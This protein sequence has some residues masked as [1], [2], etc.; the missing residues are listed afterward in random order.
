MLRNNHLKNFTTYHQLIKSQVDE[1]KYFTVNLT[2]KM[3]PVSISKRK[4]NEIYKNIFEKL[5]QWSKIILIYNLTIKNK[6]IHK[7]SEN[8]A[9]DRGRYRFT[10]GNKKWQH[11]ETILYK[12]LLL[13]GIPQI[14]GSVVF[15]CSLNKVYWNDIFKHCFNPQV[16]NN[17]N[18]FCGK[19][20]I[21]YARSQ[22]IKDEDNV[23]FLLGN[24]N[25]GLESITICSHGKHIQ[26]I[27]ETAANLCNIGRGYLRFFIEPYEKVLTKQSSRH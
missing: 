8:L 1:R 22:Y 23:F 4:R 2:P 15:Q 6:Q 27:F 21:Q 24:S 25:T 18:T 3:S 13:G 12:P 9:D 7:Y 16:I 17:T 14:R 26:N 5:E 20:A 19:S 10:P 11:F